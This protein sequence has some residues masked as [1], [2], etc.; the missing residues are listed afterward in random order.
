MRNCPKDRDRVQCHIGSGEGRKN[1]NFSPSTLEDLLEGEG[2]AVQFL[3]VSVLAEG[4][5][6]LVS[7]FLVLRWGC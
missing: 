5:S 6:G 1:V 2:R 3:H 7:G 4:G